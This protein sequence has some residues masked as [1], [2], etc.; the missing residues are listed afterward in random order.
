M[1]PCYQ[2]KDI[3]TVDSLTAKYLNISSYQLMQK[4]GAAIFNYLRNEKSICIVAG[5]G[6]NAG[7]GF[8]IAKLAI[9]HGI[10]VYLWGLTDWNNYQGDAKLAV[11][12]FLNIGGV[13]NDK[14]PIAS[15]FDCIVDA[16]FGTGLSRDVEGYF[17]E[18]VQ[19]INS[20]KSKTLSVDISSGL[21]ADC[22]CVCGIAVKADIT[23]TVICYKPG[24]LTNNGKDYCGKLYLQD[25]DV[26]EQVFE[27]FPAKIYALDKSVFN[28][29]QFKRLNNSHKGSFGNVV[30]VG[31]NDGMLGAAILSGHAALRSGCGLVEVVSNTQQN[32]LISLHCPELLTANSIETSKL[33]PS[34]DVIAVGPGLGLNQESKDALNFCLYQNKPLVIDADA[35]TLL[36]KIDIRLNS[37][38]ILTPHPKEAA[39][40]LGKS[41]KEIQNDRVQ[42]ARQISEKYDCYTVLKGSGTVVCSPTGEAFICPYGYSGMA[43]AGMGDVLTGII[44][45]L[46]AQG[47]SLLDSANTAVVW[48]ALAAEKSNKGNC[49]I[50]GDVIENLSG[51]LND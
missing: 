29:H 25:L 47:F 50:A 27:E 38:A 10:E 46:I 7:D 24:L 49:L 36:A 26:P 35:I 3:K 2:K 30:V 16:I 39:R 6:N 48:H 34:T 13:V 43:T 1:K 20:Q 22:G 40:L 15:N 17:A 4:A 37:N 51:I 32:V 11:Q 18:A 9:E 23:V 8:A 14:P 42:S 28:H 31:G 41:T 33:A 5:L 44:A 12:D 45:G 21:D 19:W